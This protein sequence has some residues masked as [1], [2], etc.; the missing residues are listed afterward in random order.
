MNAITVSDI[1]GTS[2]RRE[3]AIAEL[4]GIDP[5]I[6]SEKTT[7][8]KT[9]RGWKD[10]RTGE[11]DHA[12]IMRVRIS[13]ASDGG[14]RRSQFSIEDVTAGRTERFATFESA[15]SSLARCVQRIVSGPPEGKA[16]S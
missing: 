9:G 13:I 2:M 3:R 12:F 7:G 11:E 4:C 14:E 10:A 8:W 16:R 15:A 5:L 6:G 1:F